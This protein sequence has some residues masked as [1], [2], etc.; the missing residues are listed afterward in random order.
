MGS[1]T[2]A[3]RS[4]ALNYA[5][6]LVPSGTSTLGKVRW[7]GTLVSSHLQAPVKGPLQLAVSYNSLTRPV[8]FI[9]PGSECRYVVDP[10]LESSLCHCIGLGYVLLSPIFRQTADG[11]AVVKVVN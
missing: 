11:L 3:L 6:G 8:K 7:Q 4:S 5:H 10:R 9:A 2:V 1:N